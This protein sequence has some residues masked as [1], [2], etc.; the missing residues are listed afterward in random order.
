MRATEFGRCPCGAAY[1]SAL[2][3]V[4]VAG[5]AE[6][7]GDVP[8]GL[9]DSCGRRVYKASVLLRLEQLVSAASHAR[10]SSSPSRSIGTE[11]GDGLDH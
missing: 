6:P 9:C 7:V 5:G 2:T 4:T 3:V 8:Q 10:E 1:S 11:S